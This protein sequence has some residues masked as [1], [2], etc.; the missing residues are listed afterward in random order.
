MA[1]LTG[2]AANILSRYLPA[3]GR[4]GTKRQIR[5][6][7][8]S[9][10]TKGNSLRGMPVFLLD[11][12]GRTSG[13]PRPVMLMLTRRGDDLIVVGSNGGNPEAPNWYKNLMASRT[14]HVEVSGDRWAVTP[15]LLEE[16][17]ERDECWD[18][19]VAAYPDFGSYQELT[20]RRLPVVVL[21]RSEPTDDRADSATVLGARGGR[22][23]GAPK[24]GGGARG[25]A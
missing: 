6:F 16:G 17:S 12:V 9:N 14:A 7:R 2:R 24:G 20:D 21:E 25:P 4:Y 3:L 8:E 10:G 5:Q 15:R 11:V 19:A 18:L 23:P 1:S 13:E 22:A